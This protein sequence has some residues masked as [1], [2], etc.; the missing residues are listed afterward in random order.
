MDEILPP[1]SPVRYADLI[2]EGA[3][4]RSALASTLKRGVARGGLPGLFGGCIGLFLTSGTALFLDP[5][6]AAVAAVFSP[7]AL[8]PLVG[9]SWGVRKALREARALKPATRLAPAAA[10]VVQELDSMVARLRT[11]FTDLE[12]DPAALE[13]AALLVATRE[14]VV[15]GFIQARVVHGDDASVPAYEE[16]RTVL[17]PF[18]ESVAELEASRDELLRAREVARAAGMGDAG[19]SGFIASVRTE[20]EGSR[21][22]LEEATSI[23]RSAR[24]ELEAHVATRVASSSPAV[25]SPASSDLA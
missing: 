13:F 8:G 14:A 20:A 17:A 23:R 16:A 22:A 2:T 25:P 15:A 3:S 18:A 21:A 12:P 19:F 7:L 1:L 10:P 6:S 24:E 11:V 9:T 4:R 5:S